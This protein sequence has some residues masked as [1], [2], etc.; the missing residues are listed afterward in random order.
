MFPPSMIERVPQHLGQILAVIVLGVLLSHVLHLLLADPAVM[1]GYLLQAG[2][3]QVHVRFHGTNEL[4][5]VRQRLRRAGVQPDEAPA[6]RYG[7]QVAYFEV[8]VVEVGDLQL[9]AP[10]RFD[11]FG[12]LHRPVIVEVKAGGGE[13]G[14]GLLWFFFNGDDLSTLPQF[15]DAEA[16]RVLD[17]IAEYGGPAVLGVLHR[18]L[19]PFDQAPA[20]EHVVAQN[21]GHG[22]VV[23]EFLADDE[24]LRETVGRRLFRIAQTYAEALAVAQK[25]LE[26]GEVFGSGYDEDVPDPSHHQYRQ[27]VVDHG[28]VVDG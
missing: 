26:I 10:G 6:Q 5:G 3:L 13:V 11:L 9:V 15:D 2:D 25:R 22:F 23:D 18:P 28:L 27:W 21:H 1:I 19:Q 12:E 4:G 14:F 7:V 16:L 8:H 17:R 20:V 24:G